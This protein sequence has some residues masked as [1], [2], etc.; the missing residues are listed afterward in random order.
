MLE[1]IV[2]KL[3]GLFPAQEIAIFAHVLVAFG[4]ARG[5]LQLDRQTFPGRID[6]PSEQDTE[7]G[8]GQ[9]VRCV[10]VVHGA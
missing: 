10:I 2:G 6:P 3:D 9:N 4:N 8:V 1:Q 5:A 7:I